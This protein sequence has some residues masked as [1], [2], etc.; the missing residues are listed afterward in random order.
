MLKNELIG[1]VLQ[2][3]ELNCDNPAEKIIEQGQALVQI[4]EALKGC[5]R[6]DAIKAVKAASVLYDGQE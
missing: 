4:G 3:L 1:E 2:I 6:E 5:S